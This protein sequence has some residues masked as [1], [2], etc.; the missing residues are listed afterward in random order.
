MKRPAIKE[1]SA[2]ALIPAACA[3]VLATAG[4]ARAGTFTLNQSSCTLSSKENKKKEIE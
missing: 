4:S 2:W 3:L 1:L